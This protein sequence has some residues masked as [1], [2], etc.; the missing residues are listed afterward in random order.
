[1]KT[2]RKILPIVAISI[3]LILVIVG[4]F[5][6]GSD[7]NSDRHLLVPSNANGVVY[8]KPDKITAEFYQLLKRNPTLIDSVSTTKIDVKE[9]QKNNDSPGINPIKDIILYTFKDQQS[10]HENIG[11][12]IDVLDEKQFLNSLATTPETIQ[13]NNHTSGEVITIEKEKL[14][15][16]NN[17][18]KT[19]IVL[20]PIDKNKTISV[21]DAEK[22]YDL[23]FGKNNQP[24]AES[25]T[26]FNEFIN[27]EKQLGVWGGSKSEM[28]DNI[29]SLFSI[30]ENIGEKAISFNAKESEVEILSVI[31]LK[32]TDFYVEEVQQN[33]TLNENEI[34]KFS[35]ST[36]SKYLNNILEKVFA[37]E[38]RYLLDYCTGSIC[39]G[40][41]GYRD[42]PVFI[43]RTEQIIDP[44]TFETVNKT[45]K[46]DASPNV[47]IPE[48]MYVLKIEKPTEL[49]A[50]LNTDSLIDNETGFWT[51]P[52]PIFVDELIYITLKDNLLYIGTNKEFESINPEFNTFG[53]IANIPKAIT[54]YPP[55][56]S[57]QRLGMIAIPEI[58]IK[59]VE[60]NFDKIIEDKMYLKGAVIMTDTTKHSMLV[61]TGEALKFRSLLKGFI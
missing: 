20:K 50:L 58:K 55:K 57:I 39:G 42:T 9:I 24:L 10:N 26:S 4:F 2:I 16:L 51:V 14:Y 35:L 36:T 22:Q 1:M 21:A 12:I 23:I 43:T 29:S 19:Y 31:D 13:R 44:L 61:L 52:H 17:G 54:K 59:T 45:E 48:L 34:L 8:L 60:L 6:V 28:I 3:L 40:I 41:I 32:S 49:F 46:V 33:L 47:N 5:F 53:F 37:E 7:K 11:V 25:N 30:F 27:T 56:N 18:S 38:Q 15:V